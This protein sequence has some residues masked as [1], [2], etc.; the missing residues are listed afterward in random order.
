MSIILSSYLSVD[1]LPI[2]A[3]VFTV[4]TSSLSSVVVEDVSSSSTRYI[5]ETD[6]VVDGVVL[7]ILS[8]FA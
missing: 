8:E 4:S 6:D 2:S 3:A 1:V 7:S 5:P